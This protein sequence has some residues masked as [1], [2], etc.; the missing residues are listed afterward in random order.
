MAVEQ[1]PESI[2]ITDLDA[3]IE[4]VNEAFARNTGYSRQEAV[5]LNPN[6]LQSWP[7]ARRRFMRSMWA[8]PHPRRN[9]G[10]G[11]LINRRKDGSEYVELAN[12]APVRQIDG[13][14]THYV[15]IKEDI[16]EKKAHRGGTGALP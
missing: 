16:T 6:V 5:G 10:A 11:E 7:H 3:N 4:Y 1:S 13:H 2:V 14:I 15:A 12:I 9:R 8:T